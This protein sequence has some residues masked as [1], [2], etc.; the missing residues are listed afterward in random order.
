MNYFE[1]KGIKY[2]AGTR[3]K[4]KSSLYGVQTYTFNGADYRSEFVP[5]DNRVQSVLSYRAKPEC[6]VEIIEPV[7]YDESSKKRS[8]NN[9]SNPSDMTIETAFLFY[10]IIMVVGTIFKIKW[11][12][13]IL[14]TIGFVIWR[15]WFFI[16]KKR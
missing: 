9:Q 4:Y 6:I 3:L 12:I 13:W 14:T 8:V 16:K 7:F 15:A 11:V 10:V 1:Y 5:D 2:A